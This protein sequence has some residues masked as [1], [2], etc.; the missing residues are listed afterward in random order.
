MSIKYAYSQKASAK[1]AVAEIQNKFKATNSKLILFF[2]STAFAPNQIA[3]EMQTAFPQAKTFGCTTAGE[4]I[5]GKM[6]TNSIV[7]MSFDGATVDDVSIEV[8][9]KI[10]EENNVT[11]AFKSFEKY[12]G[13]KAKELDLGKYVGIILADGLAGAEEKLMDT[14]GNLSDL[15]FIGGSAGD[16]I[17]FKE[18]NVFADGKSYTNA[19]ILAL[20]KTKK[21]FDIIKT[22]SFAKSD[23]K[24]VA[25]KV[26]EATRE[27]LEFNKKPAV[28]EYAKAVGV[29]VGDL[30]NQFMSH[31]VGL[32]IGDEPYVRSPQAVSGKNVKFYCNVKQG[33]ELYLLNSTDIIKD[34]KKAV[35]ASVKK[36]GKIAGL[37]N[38]NCI[39]RRLELDSKKLND[40]YGEIFKD[41]PTI[42]FSTYGE[43][44]IGHINQ[45]ATMLAFK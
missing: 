14:I 43:E 45:T 9:K 41:I 19:A 37:I 5:S 30:T 29:K 20:I 42:G 32:M 24:L 15:T 3:K 4:I 44:Y 13:K 16:D 36:N 8:V 6:L 33:A 27:V 2:S 7:A 18:T 1:E 23:K 39:L 28:E 34:T 40:K 12:Y 26:S 35:A 17:K 31:P 25:T 22:E 38:F 10:K 21:G 11:K